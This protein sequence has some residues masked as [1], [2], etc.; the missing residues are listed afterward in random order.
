[1]SRRE[2]HRVAL[3]DSRD[4]QIQSEKGVGLGFYPDG[5]ATTPVI[6]CGPPRCGT[7]FVANA[8]NTLPNVT[9]QGEIIP[10]LFDRALQFL[11]DADAAEMPMPQWN[12]MWRKRRAEMMFALWTNLQKYRVIELSDS[13]PYYGYKYPGH[14]RLWQLYDDFFQEHPPI[15]VYCIRNFADHYRS[16]VT[17]WPERRIENVARAYRRSIDTFVAMRQAVGDRAHPFVLDQLEAGGQGYLGRFLMRLPFGAT[18]DQVA[19]IDP[20]ERA[21][22]AEVHRKARASLSDEDHRF[23][24]QNPDLDQRFRMLVSEVT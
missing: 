24:A 9:I 2:L 8:L 1:M 13:V 20:A 12:R 7:R 14:E 17:R 23:I 16:C 10:A 15:F 3:S 19:K 22:S 4:K 6:V 18:P 11:A 21:N 5:G